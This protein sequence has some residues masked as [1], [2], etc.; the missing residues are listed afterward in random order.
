MPAHWTGPLLVLLLGLIVLAIVA[1]LGLLLQ[2]QRSHEG[3]ATRREIAAALA[4]PVRQ[5]E[6]GRVRPSMAGVQDPTPAECGIAIGRAMSTRQDLW[7][8][9]EDVIGL[10]APPRAGKT[11]T[12]AGMVVDAPGPVLVTSTRADIYLST[13]AARQRCG[14][15]AVFNPDNLGDG[16][17]HSTFRWS[18][19]IGCE[20]A[21][22][23]QRRA[24][25]LLSG[26]PDAR[27]TED[28]TF[29]LS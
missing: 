9:Y 29:W 7:A 10:V 2:R 23:A 28:R 21:V 20:D 15:V 11:G 16:S 24:A 1:A 14:D 4:L 26:S 3:F 19:I 6:L 12:L 18:P 5:A 22:I 17:L 13:Y 8:S 27:G 25:S